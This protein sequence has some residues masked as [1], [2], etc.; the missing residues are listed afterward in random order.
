MAG[1]TGFFKKLLGNNTPT[2]ATKPASAASN[3]PTKS[4]AESAT[5]PE[6][7]SLDTGQS[8]AQLYEQVRAASAPI[9]TETPHEDLCGLHSEMTTEDIEHQL[10]YLYRRYNRAAASLDTTMNREA[11]IMLDAVVAMRRKYLGK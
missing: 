8:A 11:E 5:H 10:A 2:S 6:E 4:S 3:L 1:L 9:G 7:Y